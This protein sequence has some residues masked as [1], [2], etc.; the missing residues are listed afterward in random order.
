MET[1]V[2][3]VRRSSQS[4]PKPSVHC[5]PQCGSFLDAPRVNPTTGDVERK[6]MACRD[7]LPVSF[8]QTDT[9]TGA[10]PR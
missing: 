6:C 10:A 3:L 7:W 5:C 8:A 9:F 4:K 2:D 1:L